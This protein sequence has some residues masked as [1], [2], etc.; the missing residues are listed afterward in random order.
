MKIINTI[1]VFLFILSIVLMPFSAIALIWTESEFYGKLF[2]TAAI[3]F[4]PL[5]VLV[6][7]TE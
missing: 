5:L 3:A 6:D 7:A 1:A 4:I 2:I